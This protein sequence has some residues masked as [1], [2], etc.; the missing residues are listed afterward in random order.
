[1]QVHHKDEKLTSM[2]RRMEATKDSPT[3]K[4]E[5]DLPRL[6]GSLDKRRNGYGSLLH[7]SCT[8]QRLTFVSLSEDHE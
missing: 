2:M 6:R 8:R 4:E 5:V 3:P 1:M 7:V